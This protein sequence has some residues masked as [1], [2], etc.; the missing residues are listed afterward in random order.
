MILARE[1]Q[2]SHAERRR[3][4]HDQQGRVTKF[5]IGDRVLVRTHRLSSAVDKQIYKFFLVV[6]R[7]IRCCARF[8]IKCLHGSRSR[9]EPDYRDL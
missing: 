8:V 5:V 9:N 7:T 3:L 4:R 6:S 2:K 1:V